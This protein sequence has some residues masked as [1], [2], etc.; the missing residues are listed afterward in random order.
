[1]RAD[2]YVV[3]DLNVA[4]DARECSDLYAIAERWV[5]PGRRIVCDTRGA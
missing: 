3:A 5:T 1:M 2:E 4:E